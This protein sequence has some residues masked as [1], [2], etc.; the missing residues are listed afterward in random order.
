MQA[1]KVRKKKRNQD[2]KSKQ[3]KEKRKGKTKV[4]AMA[5]DSESKSDIESES[6]SRLFYLYKI[7]SERSKSDAIWLRPRINNVKLKMELDAGSA[8]SIISKRD[9]RR[10]FNSLKLKKH[11]LNSKRIQVKLRNLWGPQ[12]NCQTQR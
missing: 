8:L 6:D 9:Y 5:Q 3:E 4:F 11:P 12:R 7:N 1:K 2:Q 10:H